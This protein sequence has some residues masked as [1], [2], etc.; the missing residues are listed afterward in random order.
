MQAETLA[1]AY[2]LWRRNW[3]GK[4]REYTAGALVWQVRNSA[5][6]SHGHANYLLFIQ[7]NDCWP[8]TS[9]AIV[10]YFLRP[11]PAYY[12]VARELR[13]FTVGMTRKDKQTFSNDR[14]AVDF[15]IES[16]LEIWGTNSTLLDKAVTLEV[17]FFDLESNWTEK[18]E[19]E[20]VL[21][22]NSST[23]LYKG[24]VTGQPIRNKQSDLPKVIIVSARI[25]DGQTILS[26]YSNW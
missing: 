23:E 25:L 18:W 11:K 5:L 24:H 14:S 10:D 12:A 6:F 15:T 8:V 1:S 7:L 26:R 2:R 21:A 4:C 13:P 19:E 16:V 22:A 20:V 9:W 17:T 3:R